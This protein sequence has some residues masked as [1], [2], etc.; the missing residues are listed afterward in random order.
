MKV[1]IA[2]AMDEANHSVVS[3]FVFLRVSDSWKNQ[4]LLFLFSYVF[5][6]S[7]L[8]GN[9]FI[10]LT[11]TSDPHLQ[12]PMYS[13]L[14]NLSIIDLVFCSSTVPKMIYDLFRKN[15]IISFWGCVAQIFFIHSAG[16]TEIVL[17]I[18]M[19]FD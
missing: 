12:S 7:R 10:V 1:I 14:A 15:K 9:L 13:L 11:L 2:E 4:L 16:G 18:A 17:L 5:Y 6:V 3:E 8:M 19:A